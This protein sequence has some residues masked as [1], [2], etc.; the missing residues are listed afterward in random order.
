M[1]KLSK[2]QGILLVFLMLAVLV[3]CVYHAITPAKK[4]ILLTDDPLQIESLRLF[5]YETGQLIQINETQDIEAGLQYL[6]KI[7]T[8]GNPSSLIEKPGSEKLGISISYSDGTVTHCTENWCDLNGTRCNI[9][10]LGASWSELWR[11]FSTLSAPVSP[12][13]ERNV[14]G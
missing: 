9:S 2:R 11:S 7:K 4:S 3:L 5:N 12:Y 13:E 1:S 14:F 10:D 8:S 6:S